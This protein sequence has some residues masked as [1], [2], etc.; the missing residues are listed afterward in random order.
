METVALPSITVS[1]TTNYNIRNSR[2]MLR[3]YLIIITKNKTHKKLGNVSTKCFQET[4]YFTFVQSHLQNAL[5]CWGHACGTT[6]EKFQIM[7]RK[8]I[9]GMLGLNTYQNVDTIIIMPLIIMPSN[10]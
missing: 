7:Q 4:L 10:L 2:E 6:L 8:I 3:L 5:A 1:R 9:S